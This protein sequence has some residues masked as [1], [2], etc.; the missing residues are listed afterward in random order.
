[1]IES[2][3]QRLRKSALAK[4]LVRAPS[5]ILPSQRTNLLA[6]ENR[7]LNSPPC[8]NRKPFQKLFIGRFDTSIVVDFFDE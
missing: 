7:S 2:D 5:P 4:S 1:M 6:H 8:L 3:Y